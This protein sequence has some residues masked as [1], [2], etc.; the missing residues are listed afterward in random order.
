MSETS[1]NTS[2]TPV[3]EKEA[4]QQQVST[5]SALVGDWLLATPQQARKQQQEQGHTSPITMPR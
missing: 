5:P 4:Q 1:C 2:E 3:R